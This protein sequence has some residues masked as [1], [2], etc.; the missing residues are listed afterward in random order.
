MWLFY[1]NDSRGWSTKVII[2]LNLGVTTVDVYEIKRI[3]S[4]YFTEE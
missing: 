4:D 3:D 2:D 1:T